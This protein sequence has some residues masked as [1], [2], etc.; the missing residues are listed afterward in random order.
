[1]TQ[2][3]GNTSSI[4]KGKHKQTGRSIDLHKPSDIQY[5]HTMVVM[6]DT[7]Q[8][9]FKFLPWYFNET[10]KILGVEMLSFR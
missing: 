8:N 5:Q 10:E 3:R 1:M 9:I 6:L 7:S 4:H 2:L